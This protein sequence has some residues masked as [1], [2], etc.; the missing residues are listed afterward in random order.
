MEVAQIHGWDDLYKHFHHE[1]HRSEPKFRQSVIDLGEPDRIAL[2]TTLGWTYHVDDWSRLMYDM[3][4]K[5]AVKSLDDSPSPQ[6]QEPITETIVKPY[7]HPMLFILD[8]KYADL[9][10]AMDEATYEKTKQS[11][12]DHGFINPVT[13]NDQGV[14]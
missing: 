7:L 6:K 4:L 8:K 12:R 3:Y 5:V 10:P 14:L 2:C 9:Y 13:V 11:V 1:C